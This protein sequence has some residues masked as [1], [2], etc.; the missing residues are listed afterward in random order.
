MVLPAI[1]RDG[2][3]VKGEEAMDEDQ[4]IAA[5][6]AAMQRKIAHLTPQL[7]YQAPIVNG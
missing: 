4:R 1:R 2:A 6:M 5:A 3:Y 7:E